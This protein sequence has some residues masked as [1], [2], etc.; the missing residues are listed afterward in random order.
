[1][2]IIF[3]NDDVSPSTN[4]RQMHEMYEAIIDRFPDAE[5]WS[6]LNLF[7]KYNDIGETNAE[8]NL[9]LKEDNYF[10]EVECLVNGYMNTYDKVVYKGLVNVEKSKV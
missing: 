4:I 9:K 3:R 1:M 10:Y 7:G 8:L 6:C 5:I 2:G